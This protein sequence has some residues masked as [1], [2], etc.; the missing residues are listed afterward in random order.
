MVA[1]LATLRLQLQQQNIRPEDLFLTPVVLRSDTLDRESIP[2][3]P[4]A[5]SE[6]LKKYFVNHY[7]CRIME[8]LKNVEN[9]LGKYPNEIAL[10]DQYWVLKPAIG[11]EVPIEIIYE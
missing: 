5:I 4:T 10:F 3:M 9:F 7:L 2:G 6:E 11:I 1:E 8:S